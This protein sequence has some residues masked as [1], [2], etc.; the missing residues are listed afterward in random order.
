MNS[1]TD[2]T[3]NEVYQYK[4]DGFY[5]DVYKHYKTIHSLMVKQEFEKRF[6]THDI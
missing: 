5:F 1:C 3:T 6:M 4:T 2:K